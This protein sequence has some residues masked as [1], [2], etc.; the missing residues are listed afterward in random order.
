M[1]KLSF[2]ICSKPYLSQSSLYLSVVDK[3]DEFKNLN[4]S[5]GRLN[6]LTMWQQMDSWC[7]HHD[8]AYTNVAKIN[9]SA[10]SISVFP[11][12]NSGTFN[13]MVHES[14]PKGQLSI[15]NVLGEVVYFRDFEGQGSV[16]ATILGANS[17]IYRIS[18][19]KTPGT[20]FVKYEQNGVVNMRKLILQ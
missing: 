4:V 20:Y 2:L 8:K 3:S 15:M 6:V 9:K 16:D 14:L 13:L 19:D 11:N 12:P 10:A 1:P 7:W 18:F 5:G 17:I